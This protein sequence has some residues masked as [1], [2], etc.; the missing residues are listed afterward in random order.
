MLA[1]WHLVFLLSDNEW[2]WHGNEWQ[3]H[4]NDMAMSD[5]EWQWVTMSDNVW[6]WLLWNA[7]GWP[8]SLDAASTLWECVQLQI[9]LFP[10]DSSA[11]LLPRSSNP[12]SSLGSTH[13]RSVMEWVVLPPFPLGRFA[14]SHWLRACRLQRWIQVAPVDTWT[15][16]NL[17]MAS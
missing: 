15:K 10:A 9:C 7:I 8:H 1:P 12:V 13:Q 2:Q 5:N 14:D 6:H 4:G 3:C 11:S 17:A 16:V